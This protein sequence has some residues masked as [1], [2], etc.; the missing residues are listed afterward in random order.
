MHTCRVKKKQ[1]IMCYKEG[2]Y[3]FGHSKA[4]V[5]VFEKMGCTP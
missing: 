2:E 3:Y 4:P 1:E 5:I